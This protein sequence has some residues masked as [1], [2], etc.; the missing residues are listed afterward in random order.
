MS[1]PLMPRRWPVA[2]LALL[3]AGG[4]AFAHRALSDPSFFPAIDFVEYWAAGRLNA[5]GG[6]PYDP[7]QL[8]PLQRAASPRHAQKPIMMWNPPWA[9]PLVT[10]VGL[11]PSREA[12]LAWFFLHLA[13]VLACCDLLWRMYGGAERLRPAAWVLALTFAPTVYL[14]KFGQISGLMLLGLT[15]F[16]ACVRR[17]RFLL[18]G[19]FGSLTAL[20][21][22][23]FPFF[24]LAL[25]FEGV[26][27]RRGA[28]VLLGGA[29]A[30][31]ALTAAELLINP[32]AFAQYLRALDRP[33]TP[34]HVPLSLWEHPTLGYWLRVAVPGRPFWV[35]FVPCALGV[36]AFVPYYLRRRAGWDWTAELPRLLLASLLLAPYGAWPFDLTV[37]LVPV[38]QAAVW[39][40]AA[41]D[42]RRLWAAAAVYLL[43][44]WLAL[45]P[46]GSAKYYFW[47]TPAVLTGWLVA[48]ERAALARPPSPAAPG[49]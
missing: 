9:L 2:G 12:Q 13:L 35:Q 25:V 36:V 22:H 1:G 6:D 19:A 8:G 33:A 28:K 15:G 31:A 16:L 46:T 26:G 27:T 30:L 10:P 11:L 29:L 32:D 45:Q 40:S 24:A 21:P 20:K 5:D 44:S 48:R 38:I 37:L 14:L 3:L 17:G 47:V 39:L 23:L 7:E 43:L 18:A 4:A 34:D 41:A 42:R 49:W